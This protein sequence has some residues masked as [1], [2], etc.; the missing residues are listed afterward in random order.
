MELPTIEKFKNKLLDLMMFGHYFNEQAIVVYAEKNLINFYKL[1]IKI[2][3]ENDAR[4]VI[5]EDGYKFKLQDENLQYIFFENKKSLLVS[6]EGNAMININYDKNEKLIKAIENA[7]LINYIIY[8]TLHKVQKRVEDDEYLKENFKMSLLM[9]S[10]LALGFTFLLFTFF[11]GFN[12]SLKQTQGM[13]QAQND[14]LE[15]QIALQTIYALELTA[16]YNVSFEDFGIYYDN[17]T[18]TVKI[19]RNES[20]QSTQQTQQKPPFDWLP[21]VNR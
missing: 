8:E 2:V 3:I 7:N 12:E 11:N 18:R 14:I 20:I 10:I 21:V 6:I 19:R 17:T 13:I 16:K 1:R 4:Y 15:K 5:T 9:F